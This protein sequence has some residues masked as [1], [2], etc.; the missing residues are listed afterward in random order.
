MSAAGARLRVV[1]ASGGGLPLFGRVAL[2]A[3]GTRGATR[4]IAVELGRAG[5][6]VHVTGRT[7]RGAPSPM[8]RP[9]TV[10][11]TAEEIIGRGGA[12]YAHRVDHSS[13]EEVAALVADLAARHDG[14]LDILV[15]G[16]WGG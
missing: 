3:G 7:S 13:P 11:D 14:R 16:I 9:E 6:V 1:E 12:A 5:A 15:N 8:A 10:E 4:A 2:V